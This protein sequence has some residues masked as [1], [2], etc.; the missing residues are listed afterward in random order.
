MISIP[1]AESYSTIGLDC[2]SR[3]IEFEKGKVGT[4]EKFPDSHSPDFDLPKSIRDV[5]I[6]QV[7]FDLS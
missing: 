4:A 7:S 3:I 2:R 5:P 6:F 1:K